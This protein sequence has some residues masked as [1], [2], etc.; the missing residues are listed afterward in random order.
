MVEHGIEELSILPG[1]KGM[2]LDRMT[3]DIHVQFIRTAVAKVVH[4]AGRQDRLLACAGVPPTL[5]KSKLGCTGNDS[6][7]L[8]KGRIDVIGRATPPGRKPEVGTDQ[9]VM[10][11]MVAPGIAHASA[12]ILGHDPSLPPSVKPTNRRPRSA[13]PQQHV[14]KRSM[15]SARSLPRGR[16]A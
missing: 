2:A 12:G 9:T 7:V 5:A 13:P 10:L 16:A 15:P 6:A 8:G 3:L 4:H 14:C 1:A 11:L